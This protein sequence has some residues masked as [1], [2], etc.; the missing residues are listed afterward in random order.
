MVQTMLDSF[1]SDHLI[2]SGTLIDKVEE[3]LPAPPTNK[4]FYR[5]VSP[6]V[7]TQNFELNFDEL[8]EPYEDKTQ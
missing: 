4:H 8:P 5:K 1:A 2:F 7:I 6:V 3:F